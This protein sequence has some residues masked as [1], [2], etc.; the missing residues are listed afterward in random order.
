[1]IKYGFDLEE[2]KSK[3]KKLEHYLA[4]EYSNI[5]SSE[6]ES[7]KKYIDVCYTI[8]YNF[9][10][11][12]QSYL[13]QDEEAYSNIELIN[14]MKDYITNDKYSSEHKLVRNI[15]CEKIYRLNLPRKKDLNI[16]NVI[17]LSN[18]ECVELVGDMIR[19]KLGMN[20]YNVY[21]SMFINNP[22]HIE[23]SDLYDSCIYSSDTP[24]NSYVIIKDKNDISKASDLAHEAGHYFAS[25]SMTNYSNI[26]TS[27]DEVESIFYEIL[28]IDFLIEE[29]IEKHDAYNL[30]Y[31]L[32]EDAV[33][34]KAA[35]LYAEYS[36]PI[37]K[38]NSVKDFKIMANK[39]DLYN[40]T[41]FS[42]SRDL[43]NWINTY[44]E[45]NS[46]IY[47]YSTLL[48]LELFNQYK[49]NRNKKNVISRYEKFINQIG[50]VPDFK[51]ASYINKD[52]ITFDNFS[53][54]KKY[55]KKVLDLY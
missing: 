25:V 34:Q 33:C 52:Y 47:I 7:I 17:N 15:I 31:E 29:N 53:N 50:R 1:M 41:G 10:K 30:L 13:Y 22:K 32:L 5:S 16:Y 19:K 11:D 2:I 35:I 24:L 42:S 9:R 21:K 14:E 39:Y 12:K 45:E 38:L 43:L 28:F 44:N 48:V 51:L 8:L 3:K 20:H 23:F 55:R 40:R 27:L 18:N 6:V 46:F 37:Y 54:L 49:I 4:S 26:E 36:Y